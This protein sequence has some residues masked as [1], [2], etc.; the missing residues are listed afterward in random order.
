[1]VMETTIAIGVAVYVLGFCL[2]LLYL[3]TVRRIYI[4]HIVMLFGGPITWIVIAVIFVV[5][6]LYYSAYEL[7]RR[8]W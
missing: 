1:M 2:N 7:W 8:G 6:I 3:G 5:L 4:R